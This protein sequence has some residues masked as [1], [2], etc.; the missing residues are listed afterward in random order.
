M[1][2]GYHLRDT[3]DGAGF[4]GAGD[5]QQSSRPLGHEMRA[6]W[7]KAERAGLVERTGDP[8][9]DELRP[10]GKHEL[11][12]TGRRSGDRP[13]WLAAEG[14]VRHDLSGE[15]QL[16]GKEESEREANWY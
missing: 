7:Q 14:R 2:D 9:G 4:A 10:F 8:F 11:A 15:S 5:K 1:A 13:R 6:V 3:V 12:L 16:R